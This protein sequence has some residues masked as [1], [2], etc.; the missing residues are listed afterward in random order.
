MLVVSAAVLGAAPM[1]CGGDGATAPAPD[2]AALVAAGLGVDEV[3]AADVAFVDNAGLRAVSLGAELDRFF[4]A[5]EAAD[6]DPAAFRA[7]AGTVVERIESVVDQT[8]VDLDAGESAAVSEA[9][10]PWIRRW[11]DVA[12]ALDD[13]QAATVAGD[14]VAAAAALDDYRESTRWLFNFDRVRVQRVAAV[15]GEDVASELVRRDG[16]DP[17]TYGLT[18]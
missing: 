12:E 13:L 11:G 16:L 15:F 7:A 5:Y 6:R 10:A 17:A 9:Y 4:A 18:G 8:D 3:T 14:D 2:R 1:A